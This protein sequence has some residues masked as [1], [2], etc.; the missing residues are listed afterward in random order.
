MSRNKKIKIKIL[1]Y[2][3]VFLYDLNLIVSLEKLVDCINASR[4]IYE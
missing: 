3:Y 4:V 1:Y 2:E